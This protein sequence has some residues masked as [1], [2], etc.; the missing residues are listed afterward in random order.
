MELSLYFKKLVGIGFSLPITFGLAS[1]QCKSDLLLDSTKNAPGMERTLKDLEKF[2]YELSFPSISLIAGAY[3]P[4]FTS[5]QDFF[6]D[7]P[8]KVLKEKKVVSGDATNLTIRIRTLFGLPMAAHSFLHETE[9]FD[10]DRHGMWPIPPINRDTLFPDAAGF[11]N[12][13]C[14]LEA[15]AE[16]ET[17]RKAHNLKTNGLPA[18]WWGAVTSGDFS[19]EALAY[20]KNI[21]KGQKVASASAFNAWYIMHKNTYQWSAFRMYKTLIETYMQLSGITD[22]KSMGQRI[23][24]MPLDHFAT[25]FPSNKKPDFLDDLNLNNQKFSGIT[26]CRLRT[27]MDMFNKEFGFENI[28]QS[29]DL[30]FETGVSN[31]FSNQI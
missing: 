24:T 14:L 17:L 23:R 2:G 6:D 15:L 19:I 10:Q 16:T 12:A 25:R 5:T 20:W 22:S 21:S 30:T 18:A 4:T 13:M 29:E 7:I 28:R 8:N 3:S 27:K 26:S 11:I 9:H 1:H 31:F